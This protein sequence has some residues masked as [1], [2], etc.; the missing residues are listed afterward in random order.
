MAVFPESV[1]CRKNIIKMCLIL[2]RVSSIS[3]PP[4]ML[5]AFLFL[6]ARRRQLSW[7]LSVVEVKSKFRLACTILAGFA[8]F[9]G[10]AGYPDILSGSD[11]KHSSL[12]PFCLVLKI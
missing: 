1:W 5:L 3:T 7:R 8:R 2:H 10:S 9:L 11:H 6:L 4:G 12:A